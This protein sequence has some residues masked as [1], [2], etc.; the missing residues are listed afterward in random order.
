MTLAIT[1]SVVSIVFFVCMAWAVR[2][3]FSGRAA[4]GMQIATAVN[5]V[6]MVWFLIDRWGVLSGSSYVA[7]WRESVTIVITLAALALFW[8]AIATTR[9][10]R[11]TLAF[12]NDQPTFLLDQGPYALVRHPFYTSYILFWVGAATDAGSPLFWIVPIIVT[13]LYVRAA[14]IE[15]RKFVRS[16]LATRYQDYRIRTGML[17]PRPWWV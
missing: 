11:L 17:V 7:P 13:V 2:G 10:T 3:H 14:S 12:S 8:W 4:T 6:G 16:D 5:A 1:A 15:E 9:R